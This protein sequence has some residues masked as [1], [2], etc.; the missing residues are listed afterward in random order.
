MS[1]KNTGTNEKIL[2]AACELL[3]AEGGDAARMSDIAK[4]A[5]ISRQAVYL[6]FPTRAEL[7]IAAARHLDDVNAVD[8]RLAKSRSAP[9]GLERLNAFIDAWGGYIP[10]I[11]CVGRALMAMAP[12]DDAADAAWR[13]RMNAVRHG[14]EAAVKAL[15]KDGALAAHLSVNEATDLLWTLL[16]VRNWE[17]LT[18]DCGWPQ[19]TY[20]NTMKT[21]A[22]KALLACPATT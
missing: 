8:E 18:I 10:E 11:Y 1:S 15:E 16:S 2:T 4:K 22:A 14:C 9:T 13:D 20:V 5:G 21:L 12:T 19:E 7:L 17:Q 6:H 3:G